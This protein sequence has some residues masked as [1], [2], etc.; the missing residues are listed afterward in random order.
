LASPA[1]TRAKHFACLVKDRSIPV[2]ADS[3]TIPATYKRQTRRN[4]EAFVRLEAPDAKK[5][6]IIFS[7]QRGNEK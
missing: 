3:L 7:L 4:I 6:G 5:H 2:F 1:D